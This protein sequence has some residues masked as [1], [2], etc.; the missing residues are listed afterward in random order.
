MNLRGIPLAKDS[1]FLSS[2]LFSS[3]AL[4]HFSVQGKMDSKGDNVASLNK[5]LSLDANKHCYV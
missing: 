2:L 1:S 4:N 5:Y 3:F